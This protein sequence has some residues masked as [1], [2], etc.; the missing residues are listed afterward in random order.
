MMKENKA[1]SKHNNNKVDGNSSIWNPTHFDLLVVNAIGSPVTR[2]VP[3]VGSRGMARMANEKKMSEIEATMKLSTPTLPL[4][5]E[6]W[7]YFYRID[8]S[9]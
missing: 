7:G 9:A 1:R 2:L 3:V 8:H 6:Q 4:R 5:C